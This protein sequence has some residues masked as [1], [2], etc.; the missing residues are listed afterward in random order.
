MIKK[1]IAVTHL[2]LV[3]F[4]SIYA[5]IIPKNFLYDYLYITFLIVIQ[6]SWTVYRNECPFSYHYKVLRD[7]NYKCGETTTL[8]DFD[9]LNLFPKQGNSKKSGG[10]TA[11]SLFAGFLSV[12]FTISIIMVAYRTRLTSPLLIVFVFIILRLFY[13]FLNNAVGYDAKASGSYFIGVDNYSVLEK[14]YYDGGVDGMR[15]TINGGIIA[16]IAG[17][18]AYLTYTNR[19]QFSKI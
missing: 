4:V 7:A 2:I 15:E 19:K 9:E 18:W 17:F 3:I 1:V 8:D 16:F 11:S 5:F 6:L 12:A 14:I 10:I 13:L